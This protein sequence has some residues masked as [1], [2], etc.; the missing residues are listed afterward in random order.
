MPISSRRCSH[1]LISSLL[2][3]LSGIAVSCASGTFE[4]PSL[5]W[6]EVPSAELVLVR[7][8]GLAMGAFALTVRLDGEKLVKLRSGRYAE[9]RLVPGTYQLT[10]DD[11]Q[12]LLAV[13]IAQLDGVELAPGTRSY[14]LLGKEST[15]WSYGVSAST[16][17]QSSVSIAPM[18]VMGLHPIP[19]EAARDLMRQYQAV[20]AGPD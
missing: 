16:T 5:V 10:L 15:A 20:G 1:P 9:L 6:G 4:H 18:P 8:S 17:G 14:I 2:I 7:E 12:N 19:E 3:A 13:T 11:P